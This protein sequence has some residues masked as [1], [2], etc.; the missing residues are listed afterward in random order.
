MT[1]SNTRE[2]F[3][4][5]PQGF[6]ADKAQGADLVFQFHITDANDAD[7][8]VIVKNGSCEVHEGTFETPKVALTMNE[9][10]WLAMA[11][12]NLSA[13]TAFMSGKIKATG[14]IFAAQ[15]FSSFFKM[16]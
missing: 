4:M 5:M 11:N 7:W 14:D 16:G 15:K 3:E 2:I 1:F 10:N 9:E 8:H 6:R 13:T 12:G